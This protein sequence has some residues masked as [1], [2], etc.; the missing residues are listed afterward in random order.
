MQFLM[1]VLGSVPITPTENRRPRTVLQ[2]M[3]AHEQ[4][5]D[6]ELC[7]VLY[8][9]SKLFSFTFV[10]VIRTCSFK[11]CLQGALTKVPSQYVILLCTV[12]MPHG[13]W[14]RSTDDSVS[15]VT[16]L[17]NCPSIFLA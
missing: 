8:I 9:D 5:L 12:V 1:G 11:E 14:C 7:P 10:V 2:H 15:L 17:S 4:F 6:I 13:Q 3:T 16:G